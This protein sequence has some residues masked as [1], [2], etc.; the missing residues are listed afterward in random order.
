[1]TLDEAKQVFDSNWKEWKSS[2]EKMESEQDVRFQIINKMICDVLGWAPGCVST[3]RHVDSGFVDYLLASGGRN[4]VVIEAKKAARLLV[5]SRNPRLSTYKVGGPAL[6]SAKSGIDQAREYCLSTGVSHAALTSGFEWIVWRAIR[7]DGRSPD[8]GRAMV[9]PDLEAIRDNFTLFYELLGYGPVLESLHKVRMNEA[10][11]L[12]IHHTEKLFSVVEPSQ[13]R[14]L[15][16]SKLSSDLDNVFTS[17]FSKM[18][19]D[20]DPELLARCFVESKESR[21]ADSS[22]QKITQNLINQIEVVTPQ[23]GKELQD[24]IRL[25]VE[26][27]RGEFALI[28][29][30]KGSGKSTFID[31]FFR[32]VLD[33]DLE[34]QCLVVRVDLADSSG[35][36]EAISGWLVEQL[37]EELE[38]AL[39]SEEAPTYE[40]LQGAF[41]REY[42][43]WQVGE[44]KFLYQKNPEEFKI[45]FGQFISELIRDN[46]FR[47]VKHLLNHAIRGRRLMPCLVFDNTD[48]FR[49]E[50]Q[51]QVFQFA[52]SLYRRVYSF[53]ICPITDRTIWQLSKSGPFQSYLTKSFYLPVP[54]TKEIL[55]K[56]LTFLRQKLDE[57]RVSGGGY[58]LGKGI[59]LSLNYS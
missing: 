29:G 42:R 51:E 55:T 38:K 46:P 58:F 10:D 53:V 8:E 33:P 17:F 15:S 11:G 6:G 13:I 22:L 45:R 4:R 1:M 23:K 48:H 20:S 12:T 27:H 26:S 52:Q 32:L 50:F 18:S 16:K 54:S 3:E 47:Y 7:S 9:F 40:E 31:R 2:R 41:F 39:F 44:F 5:E 56:R 49:Q 34:K 36:I 25:A 57:E 30:N 24:Q 19:G 28:I 35:D 21:E 43:R 59:R 37:K 14:L